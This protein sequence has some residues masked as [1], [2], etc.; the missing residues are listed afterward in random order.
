MLE[1]TTR[2]SE[3]EMDVDFTASTYYGGPDIQT[4]RINSNFNDYL[5]G[6]ISLSIFF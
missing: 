2:V 1:C 3:L 6:L 5:P 4:C